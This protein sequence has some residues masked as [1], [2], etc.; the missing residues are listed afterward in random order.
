MEYYQM[1]ARLTGEIGPTQS[2]YF[3]DVT[4]SRHPRAA[5]PGLVCN[6]ARLA[7]PDDLVAAAQAWVI[8]PRLSMANPLENTQA[9]QVRSQGLA[10]RPGT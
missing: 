10:R 2:D 5:K 9:T 7:D 4:L 3:Q 1:P 6:W 8:T